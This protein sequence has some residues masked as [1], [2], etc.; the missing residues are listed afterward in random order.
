MGSFNTLT[1]YVLQAST[2]NCEWSTRFEPLTGATGLR[3]FIMKQYPD[4]IVLPFLNHR[5]YYKRKKTRRLYDI[6]LPP[7]FNKSDR[8]IFNECCKNR[9][10][11]I[12]YK[13]TGTNETRSGSSCCHAHLI[14]GAIALTISWRSLTGIILL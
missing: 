7:T 11:S 1:P 3:Y 14:D 8:Y 12:S 6:N 9:K 4:D 13:I 2:S 10:I 5:R